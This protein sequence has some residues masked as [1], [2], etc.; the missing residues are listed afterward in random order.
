M[1]SHMRIVLILFLMR[2]IANNNNSNNYRIF[3]LNILHIIQVTVSAWPLE[4][5]LEA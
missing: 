5:E 1:V 2:I 4:A 3:G